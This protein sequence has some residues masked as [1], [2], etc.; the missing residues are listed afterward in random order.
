MTFAETA[1]AA[2]VASEETA[3]PVTNRLAMAQLLLCQGCCCGRVDR[4]F[5]PV[6]VEQVKQWWREHKLNRTVQ[7]TISGGLGPCDLTNVVAIALPWGI[8]WYGGLTE[9]SEYERLCDWASECHQ[10]RR[11]IARPAWL[12]SKRFSRFSDVPAEPACGADGKAALPNGSA[13]SGSL[14]GEVT[15]N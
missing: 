4:G 11:L 8:E 5:P 10:Q 15:A 14:V 13:A 9:L 12:E 1:S 3:A 2:I 6:P 7:L